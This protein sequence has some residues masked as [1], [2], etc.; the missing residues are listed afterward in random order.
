MTVFCLPL[1]FNLTVAA[2]CTLDSMH[3][4]VYKY[5]PIGIFRK[6]NT[7]LKFYTHSSSVISEYVYSTCPVV[8]RQKY[9]KW[10][11]KTCCKT[12]IIMCACVIVYEWHHSWTSLMYQPE[13]LTG[14]QWEQV[15]LGTRWKIFEKQNVTLIPFC[16][17]YTTFSSSGKCIFS[18]RQNLQS[19]DSLL[20]LRKDQMI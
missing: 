20:K 14:T 15:K 5:R 16:R 13:D 12:N 7:F 3:H 4:K 1:M 18:E 8:L 6:F 19:W 2:I 10:T 17:M 11:V 9:S